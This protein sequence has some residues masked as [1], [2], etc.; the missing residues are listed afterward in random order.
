MV[1]LK[2][3]ATQMMSKENSRPTVEEEWKKDPSF[4]PSQIPDAGEK[5]QPD[6]KK[7]Q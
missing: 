7:K 4:L 2:E 3:Y 5:P 6:K 1:D